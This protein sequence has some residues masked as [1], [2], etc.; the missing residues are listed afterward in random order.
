MT[1]ILYLEDPYLKEFATKVVEI[2]DNKFIVLES[3]AFY[4]Q[5][6][7]QPTDKGT[8]RDEKTNEYK[9]LFVQKR[10]G[11]ILHQSETPVT[12]SIGAEVVGTIDWNRR[13][14]LMKN[15][16]AAHLLSAVIHNNTGAL[17]TGNQ[18]DIDGSRLD[19]DLEDFDRALIDKFIVE[20]NNL[21]SND[22]KINDYWMSRADVEKDPTLCRLAKGLPPILTELHILEI[23]DV[24]RQ[25][26]AGTHV[27]SLKEIGKIEFLKA[28]N[29]GKN[30]RRVYF[31]V[32]D[33]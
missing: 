25:V 12:L 11:K 23:G 2:I 1:K 28:E 13:Y 22:L 17:I 16:T 9:I 3:T 33:A 27:K 10:D 24:D 30:N 26:D 18:L 7:G 20:C 19:F 8:L 14:S 21:I 32:V 4:P 31:R 29:R 5:G 15:H 6:G